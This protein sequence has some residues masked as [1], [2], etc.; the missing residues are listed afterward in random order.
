MEETPKIGA[1][2]DLLK[3]GP[4]RRGTVEGSLGAGR[5]HG[6]W[7]LVQAPWAQRMVIFFILLLFRQTKM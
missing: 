5:T 2:L 6:V 1:A 3:E 4:V 7:V